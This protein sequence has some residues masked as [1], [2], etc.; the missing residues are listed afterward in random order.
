[1]NN[2]VIKIKNFLGKTVEVIPK[3]FLY[4]VQDFMGKEMTIPGIQL[5]TEEEGMLMPYSTLTLS[6]GEFISIKNSAY[7]DTNN[8]SFAHQFVEMGL[9]KETGFTKRSGYC[10]YPLWI[11]TEDFLKEIGGDEYDSYCREYWEYVNN[12]F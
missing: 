3:M 10:T 5:Y 7:I 2:K 9:A 1:M 6:F 4:N 8:N 12:R 11:F